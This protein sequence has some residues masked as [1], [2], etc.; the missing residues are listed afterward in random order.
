MPN[1]NSS[2]ISLEQDLLVFWD[3]GGKAHMLHLQLDTAYADPRDDM[4]HF[5]KMACFHPRHQLG[6]KNCKKS[7]GEFWADLVAK[8]VPRDEI[9]RAARSGRISVPSE[10][11]D[12]PAD[13]GEVLE[14]VSEWIE[15][16]DGDAIAAAMELL[17]DRIA[18]LPLWLY[19]HSGL[20][21]SCGDRVYP[22]NDRFDSSAVGWIVALKS[23]V[24][25]EL[26]LP[27][28]DTR[29]EIPTDWESKAVEI[30]KAE[31]DTYDR[32]L[33]GEV[34]SAGHYTGEN[35]VG[36]NENGASF[37]GKGRMSGSVSKAGDWDEPDWTCGFYGD[38]VVS[39][40][41]AEAV[42]CGLPEAIASGNYW[43]GK[44]ES[45]TVTVWSYVRSI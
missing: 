33:R 13:D 21:I 14:A 4:D 2:D 26:G 7:P 20:T 3:H 41:I 34:W 45:H 25:S 6:D 5:T 19:D 10:P 37:D 12:E 39:S 31:V 1:M 11:D 36:Y 27:E 40:G 23:D 44:A 24:L 42:G 43:T 17:K 28:K 15:D 32:A 8:N 30:M 35:C 16:G 22:Y 38:G 18:C 29:T 9:L